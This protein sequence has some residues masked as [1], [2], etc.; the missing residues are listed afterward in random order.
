MNLTLPE[1]ILKASKMLGMVES[2]WDAVAPAVTDILG[3]MERLKTEQGVDVAHL[4]NGDPIHD[5]AV[6]AGAAL[7]GE[8]RS[9]TATDWGAV[10]DEAFT[11]AWKVLTA[12]AKLVAIFA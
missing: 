4:L 5:R 7:E 6:I 10:A 11:V 2:T 1:S 3:V 12:A 8:L 9:S